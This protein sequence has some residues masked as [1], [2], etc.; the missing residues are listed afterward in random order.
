ME[1]Y[2][3]STW[4]SLSHPLEDQHYQP[5]L[6]KKSHISLAQPDSVKAPAAQFYV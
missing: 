4:L 5:S 6:Q 1:S 3:V 2:A